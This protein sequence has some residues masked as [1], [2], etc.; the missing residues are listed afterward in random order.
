MDDRRRF[1]AA[2]ALV[3]VAAVAS[4]A[5]YSDLPALMAIHWGP[6]GEADDRVARSVGAAAIPALMAVL[7]AVLWSVPSFDPRHESYDQFRPTYDWF[8]VGL[9]AFF[10]YVHGLVL[11]LNLGVDVSLLRA[12]VP[13]CAALYYALGRLLERAEPNWFVG[14]RTPW[15]LLDDRVWERTHERAGPLF[16]L[17]ALATLGGVVAGRYAIV[18]LVGP[19]LIVAFGSIAHSYVVYRRLHR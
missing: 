1:A 14:I 18:F 11:A 13:A 10:A 16:K 17:A 7:A 5:V 3:G 9:L 8:V 2:S 15:T 4:A 12:L 6:S 19:L